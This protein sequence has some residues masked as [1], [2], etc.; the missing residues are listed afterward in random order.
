MHPPNRRRALAATILA[1]LTSVAL[2]VPSAGQAATYVV[3]QCHQSTGYA[4][5][6][7]VGTFQGAFATPNS[8]CGNGSRHLGGS[9]SPSLEY[10]NGDNATVHFSAPTG[11]SLDVI[12]GRR[13]ARA[14]ATRDFGTPVAHLFITPGGVREAF[15]SLPG[16]T[17]SSNSD[18]SI[19]LD[20]ASTVSWG[21]VCNGSA[22][23]PAGD[24]HYHLS[25]VSIGLRDS[26]VPVLSNIS[27]S[28]RN[29]ASRIRT[30]TLTFAASDAGGGVFRQRLII[31]GT[32]RNAETVDANSGACGQPFSR[33]VP[34]KTQTTG[35]VSLD[36]AT[37]ADGEHEL[38][39]D[40]RDA[41][42]ENKALHGPWTITVDNSP[43]SVGTP[44]LTGTARE[45][46]TLTCSAAVAGQAATTSFQ[47]L[48]AATDGSGATAIAG[49][50][51]AAYTQTAADVGRKLICRVTGT[52]SGGSSSRDTTITQ[53]PFDSG[54][55]VA[56]FCSDRPTGP[57]DEC[58]DLDG[59]R[60]ANREDNDVDGDG[61]LNVSD[62][63]PYDPSRPGASSQPTPEPTP[64]AT[65]SPGATGPA[66]GGGN[67]PQA[68]SPSAGAAPT[69]GAPLGA[70]GTV[71]FLLGRET[72]TFIG[73]RSRWTKSAFTVRGR[74]TAVG[75][76]PIAN[77]KLFVSQTVRGRSI[78]LGATTSTADGSWAFRIPRGPGRTITIA[79]GDGLNAA[80]MTIQQQVRAHV[81]FRALTKRVRS[82]GLARFSGQLRGGHTNTREKLVEFQ[83]YY[84]KSWRT[85]GTLRVNPSGKF[86]VRYRFGTGAYGRYKFRARTM[87]T[88]GY[89]FAV[90]TSSTMNSTVSVR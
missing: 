65:P 67:P 26:Q 87:P 75:G 66:P 64:S 21:A 61:T 2:A 22:G 83:V 42:D 40:V 1:S 43:P 35:T 58:G 8:A 88:D 90:G 55:T 56:S 85:I 63:A 16:S 38:S 46:D 49:A 54:R 84:R 45:G 53:P 34:C 44:T 7:M 23:C 77:L 81:T 37:L 29:E 5:S 74:L 15:S 3:Q 12:S 72:A 33:P 30:R 47:W 14:G 69:S 6:G 48:R 18:F 52:D 10:A 59:D 31:D 79:A 76:E 73:K 86:S 78:A 25:D 11:T 71:K 27:G 70:A 89:P 80:T 9:L 39:L 51:N 41:T 50:T 4:V 62:V 24:T 57:A 60:V 20:G 32:A 28:L 36:T 17:Q 13:D 82:G 68:S 19:G